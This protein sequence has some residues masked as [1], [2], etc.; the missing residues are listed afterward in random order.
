MVVERKLPLSKEERQVGEAV[1]RLRD[2]DNRLDIA[3]LKAVLMSQC[4]DYDD[5]FETVKLIG[6][7]YNH[8]NISS[9]LHRNQKLSSKNDYHFELDFSSNE[10]PEWLVQV[11]KMNKEH[12]SFHLRDTNILDSA[13]LR[14]D[15]H[16]I[17][18]RFKGHGVYDVHSDPTIPGSGDAWP[19]ATRE[20]YRPELE[21]V[22]KYLCIRVSPPDKS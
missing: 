19:Q 4:E 3:R 10:M 22:T 9:L 20:P 2:L 13:S 11:R 18:G 21:T 8:L 6:Q 14:E 1:N 17:I 12:R 5:F 15:G 16:V 7:V